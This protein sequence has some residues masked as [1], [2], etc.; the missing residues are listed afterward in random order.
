MNHVIYLQSI[1]KEDFSLG[2]TFEKKMKILTNLRLIII[3]IL[4][5]P[6]LNYG[7]SFELGTVSD[8]A[9]YTS[10]GAID[11]T[12][13]SIINGS[14][15]TNVGLLT[16]FPPGNITGQFHIANPVSAQAAIDLE[17]SYAYI[18]GLGCDTVLGSSLGNNQVLTKNTYCIGE[19]STLNG[20]LILDAEYDST[21][22]FVFQ[23][24]GAFSTG[25]SSQVVLI[26]EASTD[27]IIWQING[28]FI[29]GESSVFKGIVLV[30]GAITLLEASQLIGKGLSRQGAISLHNNIVGP[31]MQLENLPI[32][33]LSFNLSQSGDNILIKWATASEF[34]NAFFTIQHSFDGETFENILQVTGAGNCNVIMNYSALDLHPENGIS[35]YRLKQTDFDGKINFS[36][37]M[38][39]EFKS[40]ENSVLVFPNPCNSTITIKSGSTH[41]VS[42]FLKIFNLQGKIMMEIPVIMKEFDLTIDIKHLNKGLHFGKYCG[43]AGEQFS[44]QFIKE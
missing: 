21:A 34:N 30:N 23:I 37:M 2:S 31:E 43:T 38:I 25:V 19:A 41:D 18:A 27:N 44:F 6:I 26:N 3:I 8:F 20:N 13:A 14:L 4:A 29:L 24:N 9:I 15:G 22:L 32:D 12:G 7:Q 33:L 42:G 28:T 11:N 36:K 10:A 17:T 5:M 16:G 40:S 1:V 35:Y 39:F